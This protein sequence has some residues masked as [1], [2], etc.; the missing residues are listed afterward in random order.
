MKYFLLTIK[1]KYFVFIAGLGLK[2]SLWRLIWHDF[3]KFS[4]KELPHYQRQFFGKADN[5]KGFINA[6]L[7]HQN[8]ND[9][10]WEY[11]IPR[12]GHT[13]CDPPYE[14]NKPIPMSEPAVR[15]MIADWL[16]ASRAYGGKW[17]NSKEW[18]WLEQNLWKIWPNLHLETQ[19]IIKNVFREIGFDSLLNKVL[20][21]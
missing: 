21:T 17:P 13:R 7:H 5:P 14:N 10:H 20:S 4:W 8:T 6:W 19:L 9:H 3:S 15:E 18:Y 11:W 16:G 2:V 1:H 12:S